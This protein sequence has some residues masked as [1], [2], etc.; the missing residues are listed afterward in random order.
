[1]GILMIILKYVIHRGE[2]GIYWVSMAGFWMWGVAG[3]AYLRSCKKLTPCYTEPTPD[4]SRMDLLLAK[5][6]PI[7][8]DRAASGTT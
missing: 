5:G 6:K 7:S 3:V 8:G 2:C 4:R 1:M